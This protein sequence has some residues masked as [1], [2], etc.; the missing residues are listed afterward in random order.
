MVEEDLDVERLGK[1]N[2]ERAI[3]EE[4][5]GKSAQEGGVEK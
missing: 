3:R 5:P 1:S 2:Q 4:R